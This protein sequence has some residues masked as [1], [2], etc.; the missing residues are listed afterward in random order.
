[1]RL[2]VLLLAISLLLLG[3]D[4]L[5][6]QDRKTKVTN[7]RRAF[8]GSKDW[9]YGDLAKGIRTARETHKPL[10]VVFRCIPCEACQKFDDDVARRD[11]I[12]R[13]LLDQ[14]V[15][16]RIPQANALD[17]SHFQFDFDL[18]LAVFFL[19][20]DLTIYGRFGTR[21]DRSEEE[22]I[23]LQG[24]RKAMAEALRM[25]RNAAAVKPY[26]AA[27]QVKPSRFE[28]P[29]DYPSLSGRYQ[30]GLDYEGRVVESCIHRHQIRDAERQ[31]YRSSGKRFPDEVLF[32]Y[33]DP[34]VVGLK[35]DPQEMATIARVSSGSRAERDGFRPG[36]EIVSLDGQPLLSIA[37]I[38]WVLH[39]APAVTKLPAQVR[40]NGKMIKLTITLGDGWRRGNISWRPTSWQL[41]QMGTGGM[42]LDDLKDKDRQR[43]KLPADRM[44]LRIAY[45]GEHG[46]HA[47]AKRAGLN[48][49]DIIISFDGRDHRMTE[50][51][52]L[53][54][55]LRQKR[56]GDTIAVTVIRQGR[57]KLLSLVLP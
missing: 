40:R 13:D 7:D 14:F 30:A 5:L 53:E 55:A 19:D 32:P 29:R 23:S 22:D 1:M 36:D 39:N 35:L 43:L 4:R 26:L 49:G 27:K 34:E 25:H 50:S 41:R 47:I 17:L 56:P 51:E 45:L 11:P 2:R 6:A 16:V 52:L 57:L 48:R 10:L 37:D 18:S 38:Q 24:L 28:T 12:I 44:A 33:P 54:Y 46:E 9:I 15:C 42:K 20:A 31:L 21:S 8:D 3:E